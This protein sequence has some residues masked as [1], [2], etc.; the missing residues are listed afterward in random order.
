MPKPTAITHACLRNTKA[1][2]SRWNIITAMPKR[3]STPAT[4]RNPNAIMMSL[5]TRQATAIPKLRIVAGV[6]Q[7]LGI[8]VIIF[9]RDLFAFVF[10]KQACVMAVGFGIASVEIIGVAHFLQQIL[11]RMSAF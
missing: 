1:K 11:T 8:A 10:R 7:R 9:H 3:W 2:R 4:M 6:L 5:S